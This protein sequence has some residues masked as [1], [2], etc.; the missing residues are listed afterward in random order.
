[1][2]SKSAQ[3][4]CTGSQLNMQRI[5]THE[6]IRAHEEAEL[7]YYL[8]FCSSVH[9]KIM[10][11]CVHLVA[12]LLLMLGA[13]SSATAQTGYGRSSNRRNGRPSSA[14]NNLRSAYEAELLD[15]RDGQC[16]LTISCPTTTNSTRVPVA[17]PIRG[18][19]GPPGKFSFLK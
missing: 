14:K 9:M 15:E 12:V 18:P 6:Y 17:L 1:M 3:Y 4:T 10:K 2:F 7:L 5:Q 8:I 13:L 11:H 19:P 16:E